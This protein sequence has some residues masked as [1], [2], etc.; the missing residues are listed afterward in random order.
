VRRKIRGKELISST[1]GELSSE[2]FVSIL[3]EREGYYSFLSQSYLH[4]P[5]R[6]FL[7]EVKEQLHFFKEKAVFQTGVE[8]L[9]GY[10]EDWKTESAAGQTDLAKEFAY[11][12]LAPGEHRV[13]PYESVHRGRNRL[14][15]GLPHDEVAQKFREL[16]LGVKK[17]CR[18]LE[19]HIALEMEF[20]EVLCRGTIDACGDND[21]KKIASL[22]EEQQVFLKKHLLRWVPRFCRR[23]FAE[24]RS[25]FYKG[26][27]LLTEAYV[28][29]EK[30][31]IRAL[32]NYCE[33]LFGHRRCT[34]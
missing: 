3:E 34:M 11:L 1:A 5:S 9:D 19:D 26:V 28:L 25:P 30:G 17:E 31:E 10:F 2:G 24:A 21:W 27:A 12:F 16:E 20:M 22:L 6:I 15:K 4:E 23:V 32:R 18:E 14:L 8:L 29:M 13:H 33:S 7:D